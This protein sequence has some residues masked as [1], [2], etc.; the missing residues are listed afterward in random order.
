MA[1][2]VFVAGRIDDEDEEEE[3]RGEDDVVV[4]EKELEESLELL[5]CLE[6]EMNC[7]SCCLY[8]RLSADSI[9]LFCMRGPV[10]M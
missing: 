2:L 5:A 4:V 9:E 8:H 3:D 1:S 7:C 10:S 6:R